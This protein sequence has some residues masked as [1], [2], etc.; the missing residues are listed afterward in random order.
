MT[1][2]IQPAPRS[3]SEAIKD[4][5]RSPGWRMLF[6]DGFAPTLRTWREQ[7]LWDR[8]LSDID[9][10]GIQNALVSFSEGVCTAY[11]KAHLPLPEWLRKELSPHD[12]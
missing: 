7:L 11:S 2:D 5:L 9:R 4:T 3:F 1:T 10:R 12:E 6:M 8:N